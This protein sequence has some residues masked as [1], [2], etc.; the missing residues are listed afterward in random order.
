MSELAVAIADDHAVVR[1]GYRR[2]LE[3]EVGVRVVAEFGDCESAY[4]W[5]TAHAADILILDLSMPGRGGLETLARLRQRIPALKVLVFSMYDSPAMVSQ[6][7]DAGAAGYLTKSSAPDE[8]IL[9]VHAIGRGE[10]PLSPDAA[11]ALAAADA[12]GQT[13]QR[14]LSTREFEVFVLLAR[15]FNVEEIADRLYIS[16][17]TV[18]NYQ[19]TIRHKTGLATALEM[20]RYA[21]EHRIL[22]GVPG[23]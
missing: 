2:L 1:T 14:V 8:L 11:R 16:A 12:A 5:L 20:H 19:T 6:A 13:P 9:A 4:A 23:Q 15:G 22:P 3:L 10:R 17:K 7:M 18:A 21:L